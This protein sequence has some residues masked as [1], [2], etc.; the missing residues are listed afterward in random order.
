[1]LR[2]SSSVR[3]ALIV[4][5]LL[6][7]P[8]ALLAEFTAPLYWDGATSNGFLWSDVSN[9]STTDAG[10]NNPAAVPIDP[11]NDAIFN[12]TGVNGATIVQLGAGQSALGLYFNNTGT[13][14]IESSNRPP[15]F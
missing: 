8:S 10:N 11:V 7:A 14:L 12:G 3:C 13:T 2:H 1:M 15:E 9:W 5:S 4:A 6:I